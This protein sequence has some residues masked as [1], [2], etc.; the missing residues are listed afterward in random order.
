MR[1]NE[2]DSIYLLDSLCFFSLFVYLYFT[3]FNLNYSQMNFFIANLTTIYGCVCCCFNFVFV[4]L[5]LTIFCWFFIEKRDRQIDIIKNE[6]PFFI[7]YNVGLKN[8]TIKSFLF[9]LWKSDDSQK[10]DEILHKPTIKNGLTL[11]FTFTCF[12]EIVI[13]LSV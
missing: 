11:L 9:R 1:W 2:F 7:I 3:F 5:M 13:Y 10:Y 8:F 6:P 12:Y 4:C